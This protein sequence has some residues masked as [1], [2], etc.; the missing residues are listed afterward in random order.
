MGR[1]T[2]Y[3]MMGLPGAGK[4]TAAQQISE[5]IGAV[6]LSSDE[7]RR[8]LFPNSTFTQD[9][10]DALYAQLDQRVERALSAGHSV[11]YDANL[12]RQAHRHEKYQL[13]RQLGADAVL[14]WVQT[15]E[16]IARERRVLAQPQQ[17]LTPTSETPAQMFDR[18]ARVL[19][20]P[21]VDE[22]HVLIDGRHVTPDSVRAALGI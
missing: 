21:G 14:V 16:D 20:A 5:L 17:D 13:A 9:E 7:I 8:E 11:V 3:L 6:H 10:H 4:T 22:P 2:L 18:I 19:E 1:P 15:P 12:N